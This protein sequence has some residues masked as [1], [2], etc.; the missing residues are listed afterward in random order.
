MWPD[1][2]GIS[3]R[4]PKTQQLEGIDID[5]AQAFAKD[6]GVTV[7]F[8]DSSFAKLVEDLSQ[9]KCDVAMFGIGITPIRLE[10]LRFTKPYLVSDI[11]A[12]TT[13]SNR[14][15]KAWSDIDQDGVVVSV[16]KGTLHEAVMRDK[17]KLA[18]LSVSATA[19]AREQDVESGRTDVFMTDFPFSRRMLEQT[20]WARLV[21]PPSTYHLT[22]YAYAVAP[23]DDRWLARVERFVSDIKKDGRLAAAAKRHQLDPIVAKD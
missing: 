23:G 4:N 20:D 14:R 2:F 7:K 3:Y 13:K 21:S 11:Y 12:I 8:I 1:Y 16:A 22:S 18:S 5:L 9:S 15:I 17:L 10:K 6:L 19:Q